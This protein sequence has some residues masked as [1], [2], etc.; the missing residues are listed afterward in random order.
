MQLKFLQTYPL[1][2]G[3]ADVSKGFRNTFMVIL[4]VRN[5]NIKYFIFIINYI[6]SVMLNIVNFFQFY[7]TGILAKNVPLLHLKELVEQMITL[8]AECKLERLQEAEA[9]I[10]VVNNIVVKIIDNSNHTTIIW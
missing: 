2:Q 8:L 6:Y 1:H 3:S 7:D 10:R 4:T 9:Y 5:K